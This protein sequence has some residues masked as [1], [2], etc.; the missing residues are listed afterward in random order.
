MSTYAQDMARERYAEGTR[1]VMMQSRDPDNPINPGYT[2]TVT[3]VNDEGK[4]RVVWDR[5][6]TTWVDPVRDQIDKAD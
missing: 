6:I 4:L 5:Q 1:V 3:W 2:G